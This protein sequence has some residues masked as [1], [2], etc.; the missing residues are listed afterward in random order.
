MENSDNTLDISDISET[1]ETQVINEDE[2]NNKD[3]SD[4]IFEAIRDNNLIRVI[5]IVFKGIDINT[6]DE[7]QEDM[8]PLM[9]AS[10][11]GHYEI[12]EYL[13]A[14]NADVNFPSTYGLTALRYACQYRHLSIVKLLIAH[15]ADP[16]IIDSCCFSP[17][18]IAFDNEDKDIVKELLSHP[19]IDIKLQYHYPDG[20]IEET[21]LECQ[22]DMTIMTKAC[23][24]GWEDIVAKLLD[25]G[26]NLEKSVLC[27][28][29]PLHMAAQE[30]HVD[31]IKLLLSRGAD[32]NSLNE[33]GNTAISMGAL[34]GHE[35][36]VKYLL[37]AGADIYIKNRYGERIIDMYG[38]K[39]N[40]SI[41]NL[42]TQW[43]LLQTLCIFNEIGLLTNNFICFDN[44]D[45]IRDFIG[46]NEE[47][48]D[49]NEENNDEDD[50]DDEEEQ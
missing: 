50:E 49:E 5:N 13:L 28:E 35:N 19:D 33:D 17:L 39:S 1:S 20:K 15:D 4:N 7:T 26:A 21:D 8:T 18:S 42:L 16:N 37:L 9:V 44:I 10:R 23:E 30:G 43:P 40:N 6:E 22:D 31:V 41:N 48:N 27:D 45:L 12:V 32:I 46:T 29:I 11:D 2:D 25:L 24:F 47:N 3:K 34:R 38:V 36:V 14:N